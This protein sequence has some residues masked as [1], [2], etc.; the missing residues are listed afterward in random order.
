ME[1]SDWYGL[2]TSLVLHLLLLLLF[3]WMTMGATEPEQLGYIEVEFGPLADGR[4]VQRVVE[5]TPEQPE[6]P[7]PRPEQEEVKPEAAPPEVAKPVK[8]PEPP[9]K[10]VD[11]QKVETPKTETIS[12]TTQNKPT[13]VEAPKPTP[14]PEPQPVGGGSTEGTTGDTTGEEGA[15]E[16]EDK[17]APFQIE[18]LN[19]T[20]IY[21]P[22]PIY[23]EKI[24]AD[25]KVR[26]TVSP[27]GRIISV[28]P[29]RKASPALEKAIDDVLRGYWRFNALPPNAPKENQTGTITFRFRLE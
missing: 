17:S 27:Q 2:G 21:A 16:Q 22:L 6:Q 19:R 13:E 18:G 24:N 7:D 25:I 26:I 29:V 9:A 11:E 3:G 20:S 5:E 4:P 23:A 12:P 14:K 8:L 15:S 10:V 28:I 1:K